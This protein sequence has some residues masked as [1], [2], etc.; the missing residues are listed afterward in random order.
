MPRSAPMAS[1]V[2]MVSW[3]ACGPMDTAM[4][5]VAAPASL[6]RTASSTPI[7]SK[8][9]IDILTLAVSTPVLSGLTRT[10]TLKSI[11]RLTATRTFMAGLDQSRD[12][13]ARRG[14]VHVHNAKARIYV[15]A[16][17]YS[18]FM[19]LAVGAGPPQDVAGAV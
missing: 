4:I 19:G 10:L 16:M 15:T 11:T 18:E 12:A 14:I 8:G 7:S 17:L 5:S 6:R 9:F 2:R 3:Q 1:A 13:A